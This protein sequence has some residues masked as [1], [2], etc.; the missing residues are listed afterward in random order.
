MATFPSVAEVRDNLDLLIGR[1]PALVAAI[2]RG[3]GQREERYAHLFGGQPAAAS[4]EA[5]QP[6]SRH[7]S[8]LEARVEALEE[9]VAWLA[10]QLKS[11]VGES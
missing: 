2:G 1:K 3:P 10:E 7:G 9:R 4:A 11:R 6:P 5:P 8:D